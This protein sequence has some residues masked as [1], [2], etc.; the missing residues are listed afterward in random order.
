MGVTTD[1]SSNVIITGTFF[2]TVDFGGGAFSSLGYDAFVAKY[3]ASGT[4]IWSE[5]FNGTGSEIGNAIAVNGD[6]NLAVTGYFEYTL[7]FGGNI[8][9][10]AGLYDIFLLN[11]EP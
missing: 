6:S 10:S 11:L 3:S 2:G 9:T 1:G 4:H 5:I 7:N 8:H